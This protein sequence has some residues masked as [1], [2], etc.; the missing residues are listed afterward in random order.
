MKTS[1]LPAPLYHRFL[2]W[3]RGEAAIPSAPRP[4]R[5]NAPRGTLRK[6]IVESLASGP[7]SSREIRAS[8]IRAKYRYSLNNLAVYLKQL[9]GAKTLLLTD[10][11]YSLPG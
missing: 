3:W 4:T 2:N 5:K 9:V 10:G 11:K 6:A 1:I 7:Q 8:L